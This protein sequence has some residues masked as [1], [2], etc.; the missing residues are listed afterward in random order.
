MLALDYVVCSLWDATTYLRKEDPDDHKHDAGNADEDQVILPTDL[1]ESS[2]RTLKEDDRR[3]EQAG[4]G[5]GQTTG[6]E[7]GREDLGR[8]DVRCCVD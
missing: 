2:G 6:T 5:D 4:Y 1:G 7:W 3:N 8:V